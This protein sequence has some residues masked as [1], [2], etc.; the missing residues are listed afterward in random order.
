MNPWILNSYRKDLFLILVPGFFVFIIFYLISNS[1]DDQ[2][3]EYFS[4]FV[5]AIIDSGHV[6]TTLW[7]TYFNKDERSQDKRYL[8]VPIGIFVVIFSWHSLQLPYLWS[9][10][11]YTTI[12]HHLRQYY[13]V[14]KWYEKKSQSFSIYSGRI[15]Y[16][17]CALPMIASHF[18]SNLTMHFYT[19]ND[20][21][22][23]PD[24]FLLLVT[25]S[26]HFILF[27][28]WLGYELYCYKNKTFNK[29]RFF[30]LL[31][32]I[33]LYSL[34]SYLAKD[35]A[36]VL[37]PL[38]IAHGIPYIAMMTIAMKRGQSDQYKSYKKII[39]LLV[40]TAIF[41][42][43]LEFSFERYGIDLD[44][45]YIL[46]SP[47]TWESLL[48]GLYLIPVLCHFYFDSIIWRRNHRESDQ[49]FN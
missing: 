40:S 8:Y 5:F 21:L 32:P 22:S 43:C 35:T 2:Y 3:L 1:G 29:N 38:I 34:V 28:I 31:I 6:Y 36:E 16:V 39:I 41:F 9:F 12:Y 42:G 11:F 18:R 46:I 20:F 30:A 15:L 33:T 49:I 25:G 10:L 19:A 17:L 13:G 47:K 44:D 26:L 7:R 24:P 4:F 27:F 37:M 23:Y 45:K 48:V 14:L